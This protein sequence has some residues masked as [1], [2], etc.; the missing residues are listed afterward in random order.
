MCE[1][2]YLS[3]N[4]SKGRLVMLVELL[5]PVS[6]LVFQGINHVNTN[7]KFEF[8]K[9]EFFNPIS[10]YFSGFLRSKYC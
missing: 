6:Q 9:F 3:F 1:A 10:F 4:F 7:K 5:L 8:L 2:S